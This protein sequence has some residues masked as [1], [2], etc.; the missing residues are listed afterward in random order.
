MP[1]SIVRRAVESLKHGWGAD[2]FN[3]LWG[4]GWVFGIVFAGWA[5]LWELGGKHLLRVSPSDL[6]L[7]TTLFGIPIRRRSA[8]NAEIRNLRYVPAHVHGRKSRES[9]LRY[10]D[11]RG[12]ASFGDSL[13]DAD[14]FAII[15]QMLKIYPFPKRDKGLEYLD[16]NG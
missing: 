2:W 3:L 7:E 16:L 14:A 11:A 5:V 13:L 6:T 4:V 12:T 1:L 8:P 9:S 10:E 15:E